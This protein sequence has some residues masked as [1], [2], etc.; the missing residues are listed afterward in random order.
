MG[1]FSWDCKKCQHPALSDMAAEPINAWMNEVIVYTKDGDVF[2]GTYDG[3][4]RVELGC[5]DD[6]E[7]GNLGDFT[8]YHEACWE[9]AGRPGYDGASDDS[10][11][12]GWFFNDGDHDMAKPA[13]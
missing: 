5:G 8:L 9:A 2:R 12:Q 6:V 3:Y 13:N 7:L 10:L 4:G 1:M 11:D